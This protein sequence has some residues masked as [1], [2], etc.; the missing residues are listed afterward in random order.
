MQKNKQQQKKTRRNKHGR[1][2]TSAESEDFFFS[3]RLISCL[4][5]VCLLFVVSQQRL[6]LFF[7]SEVELNV[8]GWQLLTMFVLIGAFGPCLP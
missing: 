7:L 6:F 2:G 3:P 5:T 1:F 4:Q 8:I